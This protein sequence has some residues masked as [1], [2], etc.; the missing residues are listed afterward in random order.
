MSSM[1]NGDV[2]TMNPADKFMTPRQP[3]PTPTTIALPR[4]NTSPSFVAKKRPA[5]SVSPNKSERSPWSP[6]T[7]F[8]LR[9]P[10]VSSF[11]DNDK[12]GRSVSLS[13]T[14]EGNSNASSPSVAVR[15]DDLRMA[16]SV[17]QTRETSPQS[18]K[19]SHSRE[20][21]PLRQLVA[22]ESNTHNSTTLLIP[23]EIA[24]EAEDDDNFA[25]QLN[26]I[27][28]NERGIL[29]P[30]SPPPQAPRLRS[31]SPRV[32]SP[33]NT[34][35]PLPLLPEENLMPSPL[36]LRAAVSAAEL[37]RS[38]FSTSTISTTISSPT[39]SHFSF[40]E[41]PSFSGSFDEDDFPAD[42]G[43][44][45]EFTYSPVLDETPVGGF[46]GYSLPEDQFASER[47]LRKEA[48]MSQL[49]KSAARTT[50]GGAAAFTTP[51][52]DAGNMS[53]LEE[54]MNDMGYLGNVIDGGK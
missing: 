8:G 50:F 10:A 15:S 21:S 51:G 26:H 34:S 4:L 27:S 38:H 31:Q 48:S 36:R 37:P 44:G 5:R 3:P 53:A 30:L 45:D 28:L 16:K 42:I 33:T 46:S 40:S 11:S 54:L 22:R 7:F 29:T 47:T 41:T 9:S 39:D 43:S 13:K 14:L 25:S 23:D 35:K 6:K 24:E 2:K 1:A 12:R 19:R 17:P 52:P 32:R 49:K 18:L 20:P